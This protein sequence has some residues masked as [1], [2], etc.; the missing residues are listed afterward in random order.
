MVKR[1]TIFF[2]KTSNLSVYYFPLLLSAG[3]FLSS[4]DKRDDCW[5]KKKKDSQTCDNRVTYKGPHFCSGVKLQ[6][7]DG[8]W[9]RGFGL[10]ASAYKDGDIL[11]IAYE[12]YKLEFDCQTFAEVPEE[13]MGEIVKITCESGLKK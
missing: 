13:D 9:L 11:N 4:C 1:K 7:A 5:P 8:T 10:S 2:M 6:K 3:L 12:P